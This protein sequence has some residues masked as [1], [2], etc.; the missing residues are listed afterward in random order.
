MKSYIYQ[1]STIAFVTAA[2]QTCLLLEKIN[3]HDREEW[4]EQMMR[5]IWMLLMTT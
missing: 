5:L 3:D 2:A 1:D 4:R